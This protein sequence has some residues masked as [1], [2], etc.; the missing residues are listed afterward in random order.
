[1][2]ILFFGCTNN[3]INPIDND[4]TERDIDNSKSWLIKINGFYSCSINTVDG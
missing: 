4:K 1:M 2:L 3:P